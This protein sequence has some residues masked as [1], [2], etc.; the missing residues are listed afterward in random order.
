MSIARCP[1]LRDAIVH[2]F[3][4]L[5]KVLV[6]KRDV[7]QQC[8]DEQDASWFIYAHATLNLE[9]WAFVVAFQEFK[10]KTGDL[11]YIKFI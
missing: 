8:I 2:D 11:V 1:A 9:P 3:E 5:W 6:E 10:L 4:K 7:L